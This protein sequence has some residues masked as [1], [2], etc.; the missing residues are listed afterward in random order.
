MLY[1]TGMN[2]DFNIGNI[3]SSLIYPIWEK[4][5]N[6]KIIENN[7]DSDICIIF[8][9]SNGVYY[10]NEP[11]VFE[12]IIINEDRYEWENLA[13]TVSSKVKKIFFLRDVFKNFYITGI[14]K[15]INCIDGIVD[16]L[17]KH[18]ENL[19]VYTVGS[20]AGGYAATIVGMKLNAKKIFSFSGQFDIS[21]ENIINY[22]LIELLR[23]EK[24]F[25]KYYDLKPHLKYLGNL[26]FYYC[27]IYF[28]DDV[29]QM[30]EVKSCSKNIVINR[31]KSYEHGYMLPPSLFPLI[32]FMNTKKIVFLAVYT[33]LHSVTPDIYAFLI[34]H[35]FTLLNFICAWGIDFM[36]RI[37]STIANKLKGI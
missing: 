17:K 30:T 11:E 22:P 35:S 13:N 19:N 3:S 33:R 28:E 5:C 9:S 26:L 37:V 27:P 29:R 36:K 8:F 10:P 4:R 21:K 20:S 2:Y 14:N 23:N 12:K 25:S 15:D 1:D 6:Y 7:N 18:T 16:F 34:S 24:T 31:I 32:C